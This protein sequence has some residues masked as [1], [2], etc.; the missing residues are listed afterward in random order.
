[1]TMKLFGWYRQLGPRKS[2][3]VAVTALLVS[4][5]LAWLFPVVVSRARGPL[6]AARERVLA[7]PHISYGKSP[8]CTRESFSQN[9]SGAI[10]AP[11]EMRVNETKLVGM[12]I[13]L[14]RDYRIV[15]EV[16]G[17]PPDQRVIKAQASLQ[18][19]GFDISPSESV[20]FS[21]V[22]EIEWTWLIRAKSTGEHAIRLVSQGQDGLT[23]D[24]Q[25]ILPVADWVKESPNQVIARI[26]VLTEL[27]LTSR[28][29][30]TLKA[31]GAVLGIFGVVL[32]Y[33]IFAMKRRTPSEESSES[34]AKKLADGWPTTR[35]RT[36][37]AQ[38][39]ARLSVTQWSLI[40]AVEQ[41]EGEG[42]HRVVE[43]CHG[44]VGPS[45]AFHR[46]RSL[47]TDHL[48]VFFGGNVRLSP[49]VKGT[50]GREKLT[51]LRTK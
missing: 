34:D 37:L 50:L 31:V 20:A 13:G 46:L 42:V 51:D 23:I 1:M 48:V 24:F 44:D 11:A 22:D 29:D 18:S 26:Q 33:P 28:E 3:I 16:E 19:P 8:P 14:I 32:G 25:R 45:D 47:E 7:S 15:C 10:S 4:S 2:S 21:A 12:T 41:M 6:V 17:I 35:T 39:L 27:G 30:A 43:A 38:K 9:L 36:A 5:G 49:E 40:R